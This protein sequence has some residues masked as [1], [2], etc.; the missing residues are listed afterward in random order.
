MKVTTRGRVTIP[1]HIRQELGLVPGTE[2]VWELRDGVAAL[3]KAEG[4]PV[5]SGRALVEMMRERGTVTMS[6]DE[7]MALMRG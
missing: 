1:R 4:Q 2:V 7:I 5:R 6:T 3:R